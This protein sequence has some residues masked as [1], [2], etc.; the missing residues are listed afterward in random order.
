MLRS[1]QPVGRC[2]AG[3]AADAASPRP[4]IADVSGRSMR[5][6]VALLVVALV[7]A[8]TGCAAPGSKMGRL[9]LSGTI[10]ATTPS[11]ANVRLAVTLPKTYGLGGLDRFFGK[12]ED[13]G[14][15][16]RTVRAEVSGKTFSV[17]LPP[18]VYHVT[19][20][21]LP[22]LGAF[23]RRP[24]APVYVVEIS[25]APTEVYLL[26]FERGQ[27]AYRVFDRSSRVE[28]PRDQ[29]LWRL[30]GGEYVPVGEGQERVWHLRV[31]LSKSTSTFDL[32]T[33]MSSEPAGRNASPD[34]TPPSTGRSAPMR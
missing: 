6:A 12:P 19:M 34:V 13:Y 20:W 15:G 18:I 14:H 4:L 8:G 16:D 23:P 30:S 17:E 33:H 26:G 22:P 31:T 32:P 28:K 24:P 7:V 29:A 25:D 1:G 9:A 10:D 11:E 3:H 21:L 5:A 27:F 2:R